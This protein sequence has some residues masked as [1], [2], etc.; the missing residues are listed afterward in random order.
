MSEST[1]SEAVSFNLH[2]TPLELRQLDRWM[3]TR[4]EPRK[5]KPGKVDKPPYRVRAGE[6]IIRADKTDPDNHAPFEEAAAAY[7][8]S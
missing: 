2:R 8:G 1:T 7:E 4:F 6:A 3:G 5:G